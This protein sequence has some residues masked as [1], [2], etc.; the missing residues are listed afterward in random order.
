[1]IF[2]AKSP[3]SSSGESASRSTE[4]FVSLPCGLAPSPSSRRTFAASAQLVGLPILVDLL[5]RLRVLPSAEA[6]LDAIVGRRRFGQ[7]RHDAPKTV[8][9]AT[10]DV[11]DVRHRLERLE[12]DAAR[13]LTFSC[14]RTRHLPA[15]SRTSGLRRGTRC[16]RNRIV[17]AYTPRFAR[18]GAASVVVSESENAVR[19]QAWPCRTS[20]SGA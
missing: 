16:S 9:A 17:L 4:D 12:R 3:R 6:V 7:V 1:L 5:G 10:L 13:S 20:P 11:I 18:R 14:S 19:A 8:P 15:G 2:A